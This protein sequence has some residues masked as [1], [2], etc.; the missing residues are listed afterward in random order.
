MNPEPNK[1]N[2]A[3]YLPPMHTYV[4]T[5][6]LR[7]LLHEYLNAPEQIKDYPKFEG[8]DAEA[9]DMS[10]DAAEQ[11]GDNHLFPAFRPMDEKKATCENGIVWTHPLLKEGL[12]A[13]AEGGWISSTAPAEL[14]GSQMPLVL[15]NTASLIFMSANANI[16]AYAF[17]TVGAANLIL[18]YGS[19]ELKSLY[20]P[21]MY[22]GKFQGTMALTEPQAGSSLTD[23]TASA[24]SENLHQWWRSSECR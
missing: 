9:F 20:L 24:G 7:F 11:I 3:K 15:N 23:I 4:S 2:K 12:N 13:L 17:L 21:E 1:I 18:S 6:H 10:I 22:S 14:G 8:Y 5:D 19:E 16:A